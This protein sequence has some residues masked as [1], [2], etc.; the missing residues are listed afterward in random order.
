MPAQKLELRAQPRT[1]LGK[2]VKRLRREGIVPANI[3]GHGPSRAIQAPARE[4]EKLFLHG[5]RTGL[6]TI[7]VDGQAEPALVKKYTRDPKTA[8]LLHVDFQAVSLTERVTATVPLRFTGEAPAVKELDGV[9]TH[10][11]TE[12]QVDALA[13]DLPDALEVDL[14]SLTELHGQIKVADLQVP[15]GVAVLDAPEQIVATVQPPAVEEEA[16]AEAVEAEAAPTE[17]TG[18]EEAPAADADQEGRG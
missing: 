4:I 15:P 18:A 12:V 16:P 11:L 5:G 8:Q 2:Q 13:R 7:A 3:F 1:V 6:L 17:A 9:L 10:P 14:S